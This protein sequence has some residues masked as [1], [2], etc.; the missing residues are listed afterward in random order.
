MMSL[1]LLILGAELKLL[2]WV[3]VDTVGQASSEEMHKATAKPA[4]LIMTALSPEKGGTTP[5]AATQLAK[6]P[7]PQPKGAS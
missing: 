4:H 1:A 2:D 5:P 7:T 6:L 3:F